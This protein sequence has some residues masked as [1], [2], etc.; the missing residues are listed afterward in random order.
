M[1]LPLL[2]ND[3]PTRARLTGHYLR[4]QFEL[5]AGFLLITDFDCPFEESTHFSLVSRNYEVLSRRALGAMYCSFVIQ[6]LSWHDATHLQIN[7]YQN[8]HWRLRVRPWGIP[9]LH[10]RLGLRRIEA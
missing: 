8:L 1:R 7:F 6:W 9:F 10:P 2:D 5:A 4:Y 3:E